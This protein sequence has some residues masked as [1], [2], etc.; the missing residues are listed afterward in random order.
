MIILAQNNSIV[1][2]DVYE[3]F[4]K[5]FKKRKLLKVIFITS[6]VVLR[7]YVIILK[8][9]YPSTEVI[10]CLQR[11]IWIIKKNIYNWII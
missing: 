3:W 4:R 11:C 2:K 10:N 7:L 9:E 5:I 8:N 1:F 6:C